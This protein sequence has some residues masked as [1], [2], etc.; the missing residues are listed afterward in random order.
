[1]GFG[2]LRYLNQCEDFKLVSLPWPLSTR[3]TL[4][5]F[6]GLRTEILACRRVAGDTL[7]GC[8]GLWGV[9]PRGA[10]TTLSPLTRI[11]IGKGFK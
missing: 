11:R 4:S 7:G 5:F 6:G 1:M 8:S 2:W 10:L 9:V 3:L